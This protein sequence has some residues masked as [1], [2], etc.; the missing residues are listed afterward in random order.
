MLINYFDFPTPRQLSNWFPWPRRF[1]TICVIKMTIYL[2]NDKV[3]RLLTE[4]I[5]QALDRYLDPVVV[6]LPNNEPTPDSSDDDNELPFL[7]LM[8]ELV[9]SSIPLIPSFPKAV[10]NAFDSSCIA[11][12]VDDPLQ[13]DVPAF[14]SAWQAWPTPSC[15]ALCLQATPLLY[16]SCT[17]TEIHMDTVVGSFISSNSS[18]VS[19]C[20]RDAG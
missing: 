11:D 13:F 5:N 4:A 20:F 2:T 18:A 15:S 10:E 16:A 3:W 1:H 9:P 12:D 8:E 14:A 19:W 7:A 17:L 6:P